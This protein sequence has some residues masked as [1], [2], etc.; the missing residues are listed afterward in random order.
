MT[1]E[2]SASLLMF[3]IPMIR[4]LS[5]FSDHS[6]VSRVAFE[7]FRSAWISLAFEAMSEAEAE[8]LLIRVESFFFSW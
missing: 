8:M 2:R 5:R 4:L 7:S 1:G 3:A 6:Y